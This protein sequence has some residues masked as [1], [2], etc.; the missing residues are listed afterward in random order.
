MAWSIE[1]VSV[2]PSASAT[3]DCGAEVLGPA[4]K[5]GNGVDFVT[6]WLRRLGTPEAAGVEHAAAR[7]PTTAAMAIRP[8][9]VRARGVVISVKAEPYVS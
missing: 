1:T 8:W 9:R 4:S 2:N 3:S 5:L 6:V 7:R